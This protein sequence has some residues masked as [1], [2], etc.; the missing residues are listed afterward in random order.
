MTCA[1]KIPRRV[2]RLRL[3]WQNFS[4]GIGNEWSR[5]SEEILQEHSAATSRAAA[6][7]LMKGSRY[8][9]MMGRGGV[10]HVACIG[11]GDDSAT[12]IGLEGCTKDV[13]RMYAERGSREPR[14]K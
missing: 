14:R 5:F 12:D 11:A 7:E 8:R 4:R 13:Q 2:G 1:I 3:G 10:Q 9:I 6:D